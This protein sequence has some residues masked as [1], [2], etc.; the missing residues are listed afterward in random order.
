MV[1]DILPF[2]IRRAKTLV[3]EIK[4]HKGKPIDIDQRYAIMTVDVICEYLFAQAPEPGEVKFHNLRDPARALAEL[5]LTGLYAFFGFKSSASREIEQNCAFI[6]RVIRKIKRGEK[7]RENG[8]PT[9]AEKLLQFEQYQG[10][11]GEERLVSELLVLIFAGHDTTAHSMTMLTYILS[12]ETECQQKIRDEVN[13]LIPDDES[14][15]AANLGKLKYTSAAIKENL[16]FHPVV[17]EMALKVHEDTVLGDRHVPA[18]Y[19]M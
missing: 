8:P 16:R 14:L 13:E 10:P 2:V 17:P 18:G 6:R 11:E 15:T 4:S 7:L 5:K 1:P 19:T 3:E 9:V 12:K